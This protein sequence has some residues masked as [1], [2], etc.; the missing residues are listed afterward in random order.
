MKTNLDDNGLVKNIPGAP[1]CGCLDQKLIVDNSDCIKAAKG[2]LLT[3]MA[4]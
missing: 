3:Q 2:T 4:V 1:I